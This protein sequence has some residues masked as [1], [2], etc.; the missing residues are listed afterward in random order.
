MLPER[1]N[2]SIVERVAAEGL[3]GLVKRD[4]RIVA[5]GLLDPLH[6]LQRIG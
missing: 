3:V 6:A 2:A 4:E 1:D 5:I